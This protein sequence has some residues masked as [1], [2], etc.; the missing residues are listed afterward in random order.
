MHRRFSSLT[1]FPHYW[2]EK[3]PPKTSRLCYRTKTAAL[4]AFLD[5]NRDVVENY[6]GSNYRVGVAEFDA[7]NH[8]YGLKGRHAARTIVQAVWAA[9]P[10]G[11]PYCLDEI[12]VETLNN[13]SPA[14]QWEGIYFRL[15]DYVYEAQAAKEQ[16]RYYRENL[17]GRRVRQRLAARPR[18]TGRYRR[19]T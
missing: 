9:M 10:P 18:S 13:T 11:R 5:V 14:Q 3:P 8:K 2:W 1:G 17:F 4:N 16:E 6:G 15:P 12:D 7:I 19:R